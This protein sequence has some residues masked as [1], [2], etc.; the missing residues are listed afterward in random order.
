MLKSS[1]RFIKFAIVGFSGIIVNEGLLFLLT[2]FGSLFYLYSSIIAI[3]ASVL[4]NFLLNDV[5]TFN[6]RRKKG[7]KNFLRRL[8]NWH[9][10]R[11][12]TIGVNFLILWGLTTSG[13]H[14]LISNLIGIIVATGLAYF[15]SF[16]LV[17]KI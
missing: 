12:I 17:W 8:F 14:Y 16:K 2:E 4:S 10:T 6:D 1:K 9:I 15:L 13:T 7:K 5:W 3:E 11:S